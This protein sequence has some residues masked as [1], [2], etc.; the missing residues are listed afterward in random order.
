MDRGAWRATVCGVARVRQDLA[1]KTTTTT[2]CY[3]H[4]FMFG[5]A[6]SSLLRMAFFSCREQGPPSCCR[7]Q[8]LGAWASVVA[9]HGHS[10]CD[11]L[12]LGHVGFRGGV[13][14]SHGS[15]A[16]GGAGF[17]SGGHRLSCSAACG[18]FS[19]Q[20]QNSCSRR[21]QMDSYPLHHQGSPA[22]LCLQH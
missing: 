4:L 19:D 1:T 5:C 3:I 6:A 17:S 7:A 11:S 22:P 20:G 15:W 16:L 12:A 2:H 14:T 10:S 21:W 8:T 9:A 18:I 13:L